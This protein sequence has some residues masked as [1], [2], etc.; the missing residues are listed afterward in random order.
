MV[1]RKVM[2]GKRLATAMII[3]LSV[4]LLNHASMS[5]AATTAT[6]TVLSPSGGAGD[7]V[8]EGEDYFTWVLGDPRDMNEHTDLMWQEFGISGISFA[9]GLWTGTTANS[10]GGQSR[11]WSLYPGF[12][13]GSVSEIGKI[14]WN[15]PI[16]ASK[17][18][19]LSFRLKAPSSGSWIAGYAT[20][21]HTLYTNF[22][23]GSYSTGWQ[24]YTTTFN[25][26]GSVY[27]L[28]HQLGPVGTY[29]IDWVRL[30][31]PATSPSSIIS[32]DASGIQG[33]DSVTLECYTAA[34]PI[35]D[36]FCGTIA[37]GLAVSNGVNNYTWRTAY[38]APGQYYVL[39]KVIRSGSVN[40]S[41]LSDGVLTIK[42]A[43]IVR[44][45]APSMTSGPD[46]ATVALGRPGNPSNPW[47]MNDISDIRNDP[48]WSWWEIHDLSNLTF[49][50][51]E[52]TAVTTGA[53][54]F[55]YLNVYQAIDT[56]QFKYL[57]FR[58]K[59]DRPQGYWENSTDRLSGSGGVYPAAWVV[60]LIIFSNSPPDV[61]GGSN[62]LNDI[63]VFDDWNTYQIDL[64]K[65]LQKSYW[66]S[67]AGVYQTGGY[68]TGQKWWLRFDF[69]EGVDPWTIHLDDVKLTG[70]NTADASYVVQWSL[71]AGSQPT[72]ITWYA[73]TN[74][75][76]CGTGSPIYTWPPPPPPPPPGSER[77]YLPLVQRSGAAGNTAFVWN[78]SGV[79]AGS[80]YVCAIAGDGYNTS[81]W[82]SEVPVVISH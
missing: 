75:G 81:R 53:D 73:H 70:D 14:G 8:A 12:T 59:I 27:G 5:F 45:D 33:G 77:V 36:N 35:N 64:S 17:Y 31:D 3:A 32:V 26:T 80:Y 38:L 50:N 29:Q 44:I 65:G 78:T 16:Q 24:V 34:N 76:Q 46:Y 25:W 19:Q 74:S 63:I 39:A 18:K 4:L 9:N 28:V 43:P 62:T 61:V 22:N 15:Y 58:Y 11:I 21:S 13:Q 56:S 30:T 72:S 55:V 23:S 10:H 41:D 37:T 66:E 48:G 51:G 47:D 67:D 69:L 79:S 6:I 42:A 7:V 2:I 1:S 71:A 20:I 82:V 40:A 54:P 57:T 49:A 52:L 60:R 68:W